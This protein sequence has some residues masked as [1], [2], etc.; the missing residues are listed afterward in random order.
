MPTNR[1]AASAT[2]ITDPDRLVDW[3]LAGIEW[4]A[5][6]FH[7][8]QYCGNWRASTAGRG[9][10][11]FHAVLRGG[12]W[13]HRPGHA[14]VALAAGD[15]VF[16]LR[17]EPHSVSPFA[18]GNAATHPAAMQP[19]WPVQ[20]EGTALACGFF[21][22]SGPL[23]SWLAQALQEPL[24]LRGDSASADLRHAAMVFEMMRAEADRATCTC[25][26]AVADTP[27]PLLDRQAGL[28]FHLVLRHAVAHD[29][30]V[31]AQ[32]GL[33]GLARSP[34]LA[35]LLEQLLREPARAWTAED[36]ASTVHM[37]R[38]RFFRRFQDVCGE[39]PAQF[40]QRLR[41][42][43]AA[44]RLHRGDSLTH[45]AGHVGYQPN[46]AFARAFQR[47]IGTQPGAYQRSLRQA[48]AP[49]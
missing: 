11:S 18:D 36:M 37:S 28:L 26:G 19:T 46:A 14:P 39:P 10:A 20:A 47:V 3:L 17:D 4:Q 23:G 48:P 21:E 38:A 35:P 24:M 15:A 30:G 33:W 31:A 29:A 12:C 49:H 27:S 6:V 8:G 32:A 5:T 7:V 25:D 45:A 2:R 1:P 43:L 41:M 9:L 40:L 42:Q 34:V 44:Q 22:F 16:L 13:L